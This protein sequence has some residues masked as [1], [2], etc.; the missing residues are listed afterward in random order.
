MTGWVN[1]VLVSGAC[2]SHPSRL[3]LRVRS[4]HLFLVS[5]NMMV[6]FSFSAMISSISW[7]NLKKETSNNNRIKVEQEQKRETVNKKKVRRIE[8]EKAEEHKANTWTFCSVTSLLLLVLLILHTDVDYLQDVVVGAELQSSNVNL[9]IVFQEVLC[10]LAN[11]FG[12]SSTP[13]EGLSV[14][15]AR[16]TSNKLIHD[17]YMKF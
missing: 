14:R 13:H 5:T 10:Q 17:R 16:S 1:L 4:S 9:D 15:L 3:I 8:K 7:I 2:C 6:L 11:V 12:P